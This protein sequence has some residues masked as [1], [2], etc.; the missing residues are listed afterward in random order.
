MDLAT[1][2][3]DTYKVVKL[4]QEK[5]YSEKEAEGFIL[6]IQEVTLSGVATKQGLQDVKEGL[7]KEIQDVKAEL[8]AE[9]NDL[10]NE[11]MGEIAKLKNDTLKLLMVHTLTI[12][13]VMV[14]L[15]QFFSVHP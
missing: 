2:H 13:G 1:L 4:L 3:F 10:R 14:A 11:V 7:G 12:V 5:G 9:I 15:F 6:A 8:K